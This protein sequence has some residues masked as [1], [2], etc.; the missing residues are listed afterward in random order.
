MKV[1]NILN[2]NKDFFFLKYHR[3]IQKDN[4]FNVHVKAYPLIWKKIYFKEYQRF[5][6]FYLPIPKKIN[7]TSL[8]SI[9]KKRRTRRNFNKKISINDLSILLFFS[10]GISFIGKNFH[11]SRRFYPSAGARYPLE[12]YLFIYSNIQNLIKGVY[13]YNVKD[14]SL[15]LIK[16]GSYLFLC[17]KCF[18]QSNKLLLNRNTILIIISSFFGRTSIKYGELAYKLNLLEAGHLAQNICLISTALNINCCPL[19][20]LKEKEITKILKI[21]PLKEIILYSLLVSKS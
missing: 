13:H 6:K 4:I 10:S 5:P 16:K 12:I 20:W 9:L 3:K 17:K 14:H 21:N 1:K 8:F 2:I 15:E 11:S 18:V 7:K 19:G